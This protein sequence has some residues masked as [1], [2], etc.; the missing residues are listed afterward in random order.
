VKH[1][2]SRRPS[3]WK[4]SV[5]EGEGEGEGKGHSRGDHQVTVEEGVALTVQKSC[6]M[7]HEYWCDPTIRAP[8]CDLKV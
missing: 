6:V 4:V 7:L 1:K 3:S 5:G 2:D 8:R